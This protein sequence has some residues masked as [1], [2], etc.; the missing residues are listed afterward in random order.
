[1]NNWKLPQE[2]EPYREYIWI[3]VPPI[4]G[5][6]TTAAADGY[7]ERVIATQV[8]LLQRLYDAGKLKSYRLDL[9]TPMTKFENGKPVK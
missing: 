4:H 3:P 5:H 6:E 9:D 2:L 7:N 8:N 1:M